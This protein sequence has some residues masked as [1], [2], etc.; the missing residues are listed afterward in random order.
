MKRP[1]VMTLNITPGKPDGKHG[2]QQATADEAG[3][4]LFDYRYVPKE[5]RQKINKPGDRS[6]VTIH[7]KLQNKAREGYEIADVTLV[8]PCDQISGTFTRRHITL[9]NLN[10]KVQQAYCN[11]IIRKGRQEIHCDPMIGND[12]RK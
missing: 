5:V 9:R 12:P 7:I 2:W 3:D 11:V 10:T 8:D 1:K 6:I 4:D